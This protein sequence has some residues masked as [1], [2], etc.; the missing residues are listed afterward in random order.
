MVMKRDDDDDL[1][2]KEESPQGFPNEKNIL[3][4][5]KQTGLLHQVTEAL[6]CNTSQ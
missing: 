3:L 5:G 2:K 1:S 6:T 4:C